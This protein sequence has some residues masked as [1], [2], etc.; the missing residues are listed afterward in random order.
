[1]DMPCCGDGIRVFF[2]YHD[3]VGDCESHML[4]WWRLRRS[5]VQRQQACLS[6]R[7][8]MN[9]TGVLVLCRTVEACAM[10]HSVGCGTHGGVA[11]RT[12]YKSGLWK[13]KTFPSFAADERFPFGRVQPGRVRGVCPIFGAASRPRT[14]LSQL[15][16]APESA[17]KSATVPSTSSSCTKKRKVYRMML[18]AATLSSNVLLKSAVRQSRVEELEPV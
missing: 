10:C 11:E 17:K 8:S 4:W 15:G 16:L 3:A 9:E 7:G 6:P 12:K 5:R 13:A 18:R 1:M 14:C 2:W